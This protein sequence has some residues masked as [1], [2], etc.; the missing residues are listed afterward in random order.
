MIFDADPVAT[1]VYRRDAL[2]PGPLL[3]GPA[4]VE[5]DGAATLVPPGF[6]L[7]CHDDGALLLTRDDA[8]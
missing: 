3:E 2:H 8:P 7:R 4:L 1:P 5:E 6:T